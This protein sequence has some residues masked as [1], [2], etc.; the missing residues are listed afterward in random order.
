MM[1]WGWWLEQRL[2]SCS[3]TGRAKWLRDRASNVC[4]C[5]LLQLGAWI[6]FKQRPMLPLGAVVGLHGRMDAEI[7]GRETELERPPFTHSPENQWVWFTVAVI[8]AHLWCDTHIRSLWATCRRCLW[9]AWE[10][11]HLLSIY[12]LFGSVRAE[13]SGSDFSR[14]FPVP[15]SSGR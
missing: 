12:I 13:L 14:G 10:V 2:V 9:K 6:S 15:H 4:R 7:P 1:L 3:V 8:L 5:S 11:S